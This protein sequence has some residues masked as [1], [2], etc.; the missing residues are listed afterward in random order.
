MSKLK[1]GDYVRTKRGNICKVIYI[2]ESSSYI[3]RS[4]RKVSYKERYYLDGNRIS[5]TSPYIKSHSPNLIDLIEVGDFVNGKRVIATEN[6]INDNGEKVI[7]IENY[8]EWTD[9]GIVSNK[10][11]KIILTKE[12]YEQNCYKVVEDSE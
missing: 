2:G 10:D 8:D 4:G 9:N 5:I 1:V 7:L 6:R 12:Q 3:T 11:I